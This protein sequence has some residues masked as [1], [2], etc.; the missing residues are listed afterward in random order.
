MI[1]YKIIL[2]F[3][4]Y[5]APKCIYW[6]GTQKENAVQVEKAPHYAFYC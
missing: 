2:E 5:Q 3:V 4:E 1:Q 6:G